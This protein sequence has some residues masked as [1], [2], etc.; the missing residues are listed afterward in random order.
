MR[1]RE[2]SR[3][4][5]KLTQK[6]R[7]GGHCGTAPLRRQADSARPTLGFPCHRL[8]NQLKIAGVGDASLKIRLCRFHQIVHLPRGHVMDVEIRIT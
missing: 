6:L 3:P 4:N 2:V 8:P 7:V 1:N 5:S